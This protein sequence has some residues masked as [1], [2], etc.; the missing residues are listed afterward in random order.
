[1]ANEARVNIPA[2]VR[3]TGRLFDRLAIT[4]KFAFTRLSQ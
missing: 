2:R 3:R 4:T 1:M